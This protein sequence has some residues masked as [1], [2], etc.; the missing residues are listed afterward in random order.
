VI[1]KIFGKINGA[2]LDTADIKFRQDLK[3]FHVS[4]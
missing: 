2:G 3:D 1:N 4:K